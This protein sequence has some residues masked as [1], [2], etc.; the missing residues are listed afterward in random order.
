MDATCSMSHLLNKCKNTVGIMF[1]RASNILKDN[2]INSDSFQIQ[3]VV[4]RNYDS[5]EKKLL[6]SSSWETKPH[7]LRAFMNTIEVEGGWANEAIE[8][9]LWHA[10]REN[11]REN[12][13]QVILIGDAPPNTRKEVNDKRNSLGQNYWK[14]T[15]FAQATYYEDELAKLISNQ[16]PVHA[17]Y[18]EKRAKEKF[19]EIANRTGGHCQMLDINSSS[20]S[21]MLTDLVTEEILNNV[22]GESKGEVLV[23]AY[24]NKFG[25]SYTRN[26][27]SSLKR[28]NLSTSNIFT[29]SSPKSRSPINVDV[30]SQ[31]SK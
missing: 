20:G 23:K 30:T 29:K 19:E 2:Q 27:E 13:T 14:K 26:V 22:G 21:D 15:K 24:R 10:N 16:I 3:F 28:E 8:I 25:R 17:F 31:G 5:Q 1:E 12:I 11:E 18:V 6:Q 9:G 7:N 4:Y